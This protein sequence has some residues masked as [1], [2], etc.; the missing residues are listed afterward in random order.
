LRC[1]LYKGCVFV[2]REVQY[3]RNRGDRNTGV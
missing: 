1:R 3:G 2:Q